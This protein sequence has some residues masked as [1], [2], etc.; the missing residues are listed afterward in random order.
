MT[1]SWLRPLSGWKRSATLR[2]SGQTPS[3][4]RKPLHQRNRNRLHPAHAPGTL[5]EPRAMDGV[6]WP[7]PALVPCRRV[8]F[9]LPSVQ[10]KLN[11]D[12]V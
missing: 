9:C 7:P 4:C 11:R 3:C 8:S 1:T 6:V 10:P 5:F 12:L 2:Y